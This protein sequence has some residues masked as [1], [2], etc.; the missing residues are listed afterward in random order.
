M[1]R[2]LDKIFKIS[3]YLFI[4]LL[5]LFWLP[6][7]FE[8]FEFNKIYLILFSVSILV[9]LNLG[10]RIFI[11]KEIKFRKTPFDGP[12]LAFL[13]IAI[14]STIFSIE[15]YFSIFGFYARFSDGLLLILF[16]ILFYYLLINNVGED[17]EIKPKNLL[18]VFSLSVLF[19]ILISY[20]SIFGVFQKIPQLPPIMKQNTFNPVAGSLEGLAIFLAISISVF[21]GRCLIERDSLFIFNLILTLFALT[22][23]MVIDFNSAWLVLFCSLTF[24]TIFS[25]ISRIF[26]DEVNRLLLPILI[27][28]I[29]FGFLFIDFRSLTNLTF[30]KEP[31]IDFATSWKVAFK[32]ATESFKNGFLGTGP[33]TFF[34]DFAKFKP[35][36]FN[37]SIW[38][39]VR[40]DRPS[41]HFSEVLATL[42][43]FGFLSYLSLIFLFLLVCWF[44]I[45]QKFKKSSPFFLIVLTLVFAQF[46]YYQNTALAFCFWFFLALGVVSFERPISEKKIKLREFPEL[47]LVFSVIFILLGIAFLLGSYFF[48]KYYLA[49]VN[50]LKAITSQDVAEMESLLRKAIELHPN[51]PNYRVALVRNL[52]SQ[53][54]NESAK[55][56]PD[57]AK[58]HNMISETFR[59]ARI[60]TH[61]LSD[62]Q[63][64]IIKKALSPNNVVS[65]DTLGRVCR[66]IQPFTQGATDWAI[67]A[68]E[69]TL[70]LEPT[71]P[72][73]WTELGKLYLVKN[74]I[75]KAKECLKR[76]REL[77]SDYVETLLQEALILE[78]ENNLD[79]AIKKMEEIVA[80]YP[81]HIEARFQLGRL[82][83][84]KKRIDD[85]ISH[86]E[87]VLTLFPNHSNSLYS[88]GI[89]YSQ[90][91]DKK[92]ALSFFE[93]VLEL[94][95][96]NQDVI[97][98][99]EQLKREIE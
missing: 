49:D 95:P 14:F 61:G 36:Q 16:L 65:W 69:K 84:N 56:K 30:Q 17:K 78:R 39:R 5:P 93:K 88:L 67:R 53:I 22:L 40:F 1:T 4:F 74:E 96:G 90:K 77:K 66:D 70:E 98:K 72:V 8:A 80:N 76:A 34:H 91:G 18:N 38:W 21:V 75:E 44:L 25:L 63:G 62:Q 23:L 24:F 54:K 87:S 58:L 59:E 48:G 97:Q 46:F 60:L 20:L 45:S 99:I 47:S 89:C 94:N 73:L 6:F 26:R 28:I 10:K 9:L 7:S 2:T 35:S 29:S 37:E 33:A 64:R 81:L 32:S 11:E 57:A 71:N 42:G 13:I 68:F 92:K 51:N 82:Y 79:E 3:L 27:L 83:Y 43:F 19:V 15:R 50:Y 86:F 41:S 52:L 85:A 31:M 55:P 12:I